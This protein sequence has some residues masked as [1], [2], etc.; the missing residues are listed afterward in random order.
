VEPK[1]QSFR[2]RWSQKFNLLEK[3]G[4][5]YV[6]KIDEQIVVVFQ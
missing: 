5:S 2:K 1:I 3:G 6:L 4:A